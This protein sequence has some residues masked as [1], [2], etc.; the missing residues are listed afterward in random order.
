M[1][2][3]VELPP[4]VYDDLRRLAAAKLAGQ[5]PGHTLDA[6]GLV[7]EAWL[8]LADASIEVVGGT[9]P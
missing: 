3:P 2:A 4:Q 1:T 7:H 6:T 9:R 5:N 8:R